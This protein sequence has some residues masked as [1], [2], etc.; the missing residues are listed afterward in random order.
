M[1]GIDARALRVPVVAA[2]MFL[3]SGPELVV[4]SCAAG[5]VGA[6]PSPN[7]RTAAQLDEWMGAITDG[8]RSAQASGATVGP[9]AANVI[10]HSSNGRLADDL[11]LIAEYRPPLV[12]TAL[13]SPKPAI[14]TV[15]GYGGAV[16]GDVVSLRLA[17][18]A[19]D[20][21]V[22]GL[23]CVAAGS[24]GHTGH[25]SPFAFVSAVREFFDGTVIVGGG[26]TNG[27]GVAG[28]I[29]SGADL[30]YM[31]TRFLATAESMASA[32]YKQMVVD[33]GADDIMV[34]AAITGTPASWLVPSLLANGYDPATMNDGPPPERHYGDP[35]AP[36]RWKDIWAAGQGLQTIRA[37]VP[38]A[39]VVD[40]LEAEYDAA[41][42]DM[43]SR[44]AGRAQPVGAR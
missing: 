41:L 10:T 9:W 7:C 40:E 12:I 15:H 6:F 36:K 44:L 5:I 20:A 39:A 26:I 4:A 29:A 1:T 11:R 37:V 13:G 23:A 17:H 21:G 8:I 25:L 35:D 34:S 16:I 42:A 27:R 38:T 3:V 33:N 2:P 31:G 24:G 28:A 22:D 43:A 14:E 32:E 18:K 19:V 30:V